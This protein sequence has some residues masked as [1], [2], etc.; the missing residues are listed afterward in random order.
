MN[1]ALV[2]VVK[3]DT[4]I[5]EEQVRIQFDGVVYLTDGWASAPTVEPYCKSLWIITPKSEGGTEKH[6]QDATFKT[7]VVS[8]PAYDKR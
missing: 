3:D 7:M 1:G 8:L 4:T 5:V 6:V 2:K